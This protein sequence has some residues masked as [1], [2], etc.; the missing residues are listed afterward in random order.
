MIRLQDIDRALLGVVG[1]A[2][3]YNPA[4]TIDAELC[5]SESGLTFQAAHPLLTLDNIAATMPDDYLFAYP[6]WN[7]LYSYVVGQ[8]VRHEGKVWICNKDNTG[9]EPQLSDFNADFNNDFGSENAG[10]WVV[11]PY[12]SD[13]LR[14]N[15]VDGIHAVVQR[16]LQDKELTEETKSLLER[17]AFFDGAA[18]LE[19]IIEPTGKLVGLEI[20]PVRAMGVTTKIERVGLQMIGATG[21]VT[22]YL[23]H[24]S[25]REPVRVLKFDYTNS[26]GGFQWFV[27]KEDVFLPYK[28]VT[29][30]DGGAWYLV[31]N[32]DELPR[33]MR[34]LNI[35]KDWSRSDC[36]TCGAIEYIKEISK[37]IRVSP[38]KTAVPDGWDE[39]PRM[40]D[41]GMLAYTSTVNYGINLEIS[42]G[43]D[44]SDFI[45]TQ[46]GIFATAIQKQVAANVLRTVA[47]N[48]DVR[49]N[50]N[51]ANV[52]RDQ[53]LYEID[54]NP[55][56][57]PSG[58]GYELNLAYKA[59]SLDTRNLDRIC[60]QCN[61]HGVKY[62]T[63]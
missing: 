41:N 48:P 34:A 39:S 19:S 29:T 46:R 50:R 55:Q 5:K 58:L 36:R 43:C 57:R 4:R 14:R 42:V 9:V 45:I 21:E 56:G 52:T 33:W 1:W 6:D 30:D 54:G 35:A 37:Y 16:F 47:M 2:Q 40:F 32:Q 26:S 8:K 13:Y 53:L 49:V 11:Y 10:E 24:S 23:F 3:D 63:V 27:P 59:L 51:Q 61:N 44:L 60:L 31:Y 18:R 7:A 12:L 25:L 15:T 28:G 62:R 22:M 20:E 17:R 38:F